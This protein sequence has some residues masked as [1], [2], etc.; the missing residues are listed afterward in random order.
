[1]LDNPHLYWND[2]QVAADL[3]SRQS[4]VTDYA[5]EVEAQLPRGARIFELGCSAG[6]DAGYFGQMGH[7]VTALDVSAPLIEVAAQRYA[8]LQHVHFIKGDVRDAFPV[9]GQSQDC[10]YARLS[11]HYFSHLVTLS[12]FGEIAWVLR[13]GGRFFVACRSVEDPLYGRGV[14]VE[15]A[16]FA[17]DNHTRH[18]FS[19]DYMRELLELSGFQNI[20]ISAGKQQLY[21]EHAAYVKASAIASNN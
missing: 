17:L 3:R 15:P 8:D 6:D 5:K 16:M 7:H 14:E 18:F 1:M 12:I 21:G 9:G 19:I 20:E 13:P 11:L 4:G 2:P 10:V